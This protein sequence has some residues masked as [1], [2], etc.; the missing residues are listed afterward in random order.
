MRKSAFVAVAS[1]A[2]AFA[3]LASAAPAA[4]VITHQKALAGNV[5]P[6]DAAGYPVTISQPGSYVLGSNLNVPPNQIGIDVRNHEVTIDGAGYR[7]HG[8]VPGR[9]SIGIRNAFNGLTIT[10][11]TI[12]WFKTAGIWSNTGDSVALDN[13]RVLVNGSGTTGYGVLLRDFVNIRNS[14]ISLNATG[15]SC[16]DS[17]HVESSIASNNR[18]D[19]IRVG[20][21]GHVRGSTIRNNG[22]SGISGLE[23]V[24]VEGNLIA[25]NG[26]RGVRLESGLLLGSTIADNGDYA[27]WDNGSGDTGFA[28]NIFIRNNPEGDS[29]VAG[30]LGFQPNACIGLPC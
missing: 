2:V 25:S 10:D 23:F 28:G 27:L 16:R 9:A 15:I 7:M 26:Y 20:A 12:V 5:T 19:G 4:I 30:G 3:A 1:V 8:G 21:G 18:L 14:N 17:C 29:Q 24:H 13:V 22:S 6:G 11:V